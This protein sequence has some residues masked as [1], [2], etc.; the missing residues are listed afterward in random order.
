MWPAE[1][2]VSKDFLKHLEGT[3]IKWIATDEAILAKSKGYAPSLDEAS[4]P[5][6]YNGKHIFFRNHTLSDKIGFVYS[7][8]N[9]DD[10]VNNFIEEL[11]HFRHVLTKE[12]AV[13]T[14]IL[15]GENAW[16][17]YEDHGEPFLTALFERLGNTDWINLTTFDEYIDN[18]K[19]SIPALDKLM[20][21]SWIDGNFNTWI[22]EPVKNKYWEY[23]FHLNNIIENRKANNLIPEKTLLEI[24]EHFMIAQGSDWMWWAGEG[25]SSANDLDFDLLFRNYLTKIYQLL[26]IDLPSELL[27]PL[28]S[29]VE[30]VSYKKPLHLIKPNITGKLDDYYGWASS[31]E[32]LAE[33][34]AI[35]K[36][37]SIINK[38]LFGFDDENMYFQISLNIE[39]KTLAK[40]G[41]MFAVEFIDFDKQIDLVSNKDG[42]LAFSDEICEA[43][44]KFNLIKPSFKPNEKIRFKVLLKEN[45]KVIE[46]MPNTDIIVVEYPSADF[47]LTNW[48]V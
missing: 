8:W 13:V 32:I 37:D 35:H 10:A 33:Q 19:E 48:Y 29:K 26:D 24:E 16:E 23:L 1:G 12:N 27:S 11:S 43:S 36:T 47:D 17:Y 9:K 15:D 5:Y 42:V 14:V 20:P 28:Y 25:H 4:S 38:V 34:G 44:I 41:L 7:N 31:G 45:N 3:K 21:G 39:P 30:T 2:S 22:N 18:N 6:T 40:K 46:R